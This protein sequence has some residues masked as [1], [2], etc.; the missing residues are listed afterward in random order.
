MA[1]IPSHWSTYDERNYKGTP[2]S[3]DAPPAL[4]LRV[5]VVSFPSKT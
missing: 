5:P 3:S 4:R 1:Y 2:E